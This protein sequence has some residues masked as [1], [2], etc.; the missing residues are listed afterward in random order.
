MYICVVNVVNVQGGGGV[1][2][3]RSAVHPKTLWVLP[4]VQSLAGGYLFQL[5]DPQ[6]IALNY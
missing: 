5:L 2:Q 6:D 4:G 1:R 3:G